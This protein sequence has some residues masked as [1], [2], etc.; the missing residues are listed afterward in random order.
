MIAC[1]SSKVSNVTVLAG[2]LSGYE[3]DRAAGDGGCEVAS[4]VQP[5]ASPS[6][7]P[8]TFS[9]VSWYT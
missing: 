1:E 5:L 3:Q 4:Q 8:D 9:L 7:D 2:W 6:R